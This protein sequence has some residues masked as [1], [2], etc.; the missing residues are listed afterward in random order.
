MDKIVYESLIQQIIEA[1]DFNPRPV[2]DKETYEETIYRRL[3][4]FA[5]LEA[6][7]RYRAMTLLD[8]EQKSL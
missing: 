5:R 2:P 1:K 6:K 3:M 4:D 7:N 8:H